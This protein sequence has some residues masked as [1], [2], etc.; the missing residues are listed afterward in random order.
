MIVENGQPSRGDHVVLALKSSGGSVSEYGLAASQLERLKS[1]GFKLTVCVDEVAASGGYMMACVADTIVAAP[2]SMLGSIGVMSIVPN[3]AERL[4]REGVTVEEISAGKYKT[5]LM[6]YSV[7]SPDKRE[8]AQ[9]HVDSIHVL[10]KRF[11][12]THRPSLD[13][14]E[15]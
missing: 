11:V 14:S 9:G 10:F 5:T 1:A 3:F 4:K 7:T 2:F 6:P 8:K 12:G 15:P 13:T